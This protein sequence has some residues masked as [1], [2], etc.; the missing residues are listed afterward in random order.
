MSK[1]AILDAGKTDVVKESAGRY[2]EMSRLQLVK[3]CRDRD[4]DYK[5]VSKDVEA[6]KQLLIAADS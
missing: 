6:L 4:L 5:A 3:L 2:E 1:V